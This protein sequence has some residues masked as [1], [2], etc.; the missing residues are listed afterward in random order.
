MAAKHLHPVLYTCCL[1]LV[2]VM[3][4]VTSVNL[5]LEE[6]AVALQGQGQ[7]PVGDAGAER[8]LLRVLL[9]DVRG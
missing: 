7:R 4:S 3:A 9:V 6:I 8:R 2:L 1:A 5:A